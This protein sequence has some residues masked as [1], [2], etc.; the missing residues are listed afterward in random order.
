LHCAKSNITVKTGIFHG[1]G[2]AEA[3]PDFQGGWQMKY[4]G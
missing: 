2:V 4:G 1:Y 3:P